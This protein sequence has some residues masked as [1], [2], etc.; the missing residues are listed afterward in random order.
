MSLRPLLVRHEI[1]YTFDYKAFPINLH[2]LKGAEANCVKK[3][4]VM[5]NEL[6]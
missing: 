2:F 4:T 3:V 1:F 6:D 5:K